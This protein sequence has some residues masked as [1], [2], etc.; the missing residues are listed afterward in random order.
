MVRSLRT[1]V[2]PTPDAWI[3]YY[4][5]LYKADEWTKE[6]LQRRLPWY[7]PFEPLHLADDSHLSDP[8]VWAEPAGWVGRDGDL[9]SAAEWTSNQLD[10]WFGHRG[11]FK[12]L[13]RTEDLPAPTRRYRPLRG[14]TAQKTPR[15]NPTTTP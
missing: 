4:G 9:F 5:T 13:W 2:A 10:K 12:P 14:V 6:T 1:P 11:P 3:D 15:D 8:A 7:A